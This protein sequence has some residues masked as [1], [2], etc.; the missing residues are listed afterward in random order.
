MTISA[1]LA[2]LCGVT[3]AMAQDDAEGCKDHPLFTRMPG[4]YLASCSASQ[5]DMRAFPVGA[6]DN[7]GMVKGVQVEGPVQFLSYAMKEGVTPA[8]GL[9]LMRNFENAAKKAG[10]TIEGQW[11]G[12][13]KAKY[14][15]EHMPEMGNGCMS[16]GLTMKFV[17]GGKET[18]AFFMAS[19]DEG[20]YALTVTQREAMKQEV[21]VTEMADQLTRDGF[22][23]LYVTFDTG[24]A[25]LTTDSAQTLDAAAAALKAAADLKIEVGG[26]TDNVGTPE[27]NLKLSD[28]RAKA[29]M[30]ALIERG[31]PAAR[32]T[33]KGYGQ[34]TP[35]ADNRTEDGRAKNRRVELVKK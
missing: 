26:H 13:C 16:Y 28:E 20:T 4:M 2:C 29:V 32:L 19:Q 11:P 23:T 15:D 5:F 8:S 18:W 1:L 31:V 21:S 14:D 34:T 10:G 12:W 33:A 27:A 7:D 24:K 17:K 6:P 3:P 30:A 25:T 22:I 35:V 9:Q